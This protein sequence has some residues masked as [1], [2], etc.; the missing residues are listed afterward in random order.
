M[1]Y[2]QVGPLKD[3]EIH[4]HPVLMPQF[5]IFFPSQK[6]AMGIHLSS[7]LSETKYLGLIE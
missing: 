1:F 3:P 2:S 7:T 4:H 5:R 6:A